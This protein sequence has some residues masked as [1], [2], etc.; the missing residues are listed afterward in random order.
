MAASPDFGDGLD[1]VHGL[2]VALGNTGHGFNART[3]LRVGD[4]F[5]R[6][7]RCSARSL[8]PSLLEESQAYPTFWIGS[9]RRPHRRRR[10]HDDWYRPN[11]PHQHVRALGYSGHSCFRSTVHGLP[12]WPTTNRDSAPLLRR[13]RRH[14]P[15]IDRHRF[16]S[17]STRLDLLC[18]IHFRWSL[19]YILV[20]RYMAHK[21]GAGGLSVIYNILVPRYVAHKGGGVDMAGW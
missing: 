15:R 12:R 5:R 13:M 10:P 18:Y 9:P 4:R 1:W 11:R 8:S 6:P 14:R 16:A 19:C 21:G 3:S 7:T 2:T 17:C 20:P